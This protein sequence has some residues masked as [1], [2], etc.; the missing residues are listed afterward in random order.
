MTGLPE[1]NY[2]AFNAA[3]EE[4]RAKGWHV[5][6]PAAN[7]E[8]PCKSWQGYMRM[9]LAQLVTCDAVWLLDGWMSSEGALLEVQVAQALRLEFPRKRVKG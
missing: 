1:F 4:L 6:N 9:A 3:A 8:P 5:E 7:P 2:P